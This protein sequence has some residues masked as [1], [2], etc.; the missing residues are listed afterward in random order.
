MK[1]SANIVDTCKKICAPVDIKMSF[2]NK[3]LKLFISV[4]N[5]GGGRREASDQCEFGVLCSL[6]AE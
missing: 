4:I 1:C 3:C 6:A 5:G 2:Q